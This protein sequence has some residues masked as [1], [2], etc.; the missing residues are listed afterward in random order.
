MGAEAYAALASIID[1]AARKG[2]KTFAA[3]PT[4]VGLPALPLPPPP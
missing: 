4:L 2:I 3:L 1:T